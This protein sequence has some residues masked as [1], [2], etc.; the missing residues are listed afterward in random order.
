[1]AV[2]LWEV[3]EVIFNRGLYLPELDFWLDPREAKDSAFVSHAHADHF[4]R[5]GRTL[6]STVTAVLLRKRFRMPEERL[7]AAG[8][9]AT[10]EREGFRLRLLAAGH[11]SGSAM[12]HITRKR[13]G[14]TL[15]YTGDFKVRRSRTAEAV[16][17]MQA[18]TLITETTFGLP[19]FVFPPQLEVEAAVLR[20]VHDAFADGEVPVLLGYS[21]GKAQE[22]VALL[23]EN[24]IPVLSHPAVAEM[25]AACRL[26]GVDL[27]EPVVFEG[28]AQEG[29]AIVAPPN[30]ARSKLMREVK[31]RRFAML[32]GWALQE[33]SFFRYPSQHV[34]ALSDHADH[35]GLLECITRVRPK[36]VL[37]VHGY[38]K[39]FAAELRG[40]GMDAWSAMGGDQLELSL[41][42][43]S[44]H[45]VGAAS[46][47]HIRPICQLADFSD[48]C[49]L[50]GETSSR[51][52]KVDYLVNYLRGI[53]EEEDLKCVARWLCG[54]ALPRQAGRR[55]LEPGNVLLKR[56]LLAIPGMKPERYREVF[57]VEK[58]DMARTARVLLQE[59][60]LAPYPLK[61]LDLQEFFLNLAASSDS[62][63]RVALLSGR[64]VELHPS[65]GETVVK[66]LTGQL[67]IGLETELVEEALGKAFE[68]SAADV[69]RAC[70]LTGDLG[71][72]ACLA[73]QGRLGEAVL[74]LLVPV[75]GMLAGSFQKSTE[76][77]GNEEL[78]EFAG[79]PFPLPI[80]LEPKYDGIRAQLHKRGGEIGLFAHDL[81]PL[82]RVFPELIEA[83]R[84]LPGDFILDGELI[85]YVEGRKLGVADLQKRLHPRRIGGDLFMETKQ[86]AAAIP[87]SFI[88]FDVLW[89]EGGSLLDQPLEMRRRVL[90]ALPL[91]GMVGRSKV[92]MT[93]GAADVAGEFKQA[94]QEGHEGLIAKDPASHYFPGAGGE[95]WIKL[96][97]IMP[98]LNCLVIYAE[99]GA[100]NRPGSLGDYTIA[101]RDEETDSLRAIGKVSS[102]LSADEI[103]E[104]TE[105][106]KKHTLGRE[107]RKRR[108]VPNLLLEIAFQSIGKSARYDCGFFLRKARIKSI[109]YGKDSS[110]IDT[111]DTIKSLLPR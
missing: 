101:V 56:A 15:L 47:R 69:R 67:G 51:L 48:V 98:T 35:P 87:L 74:T 26:A 8:F 105:H 13:D 97:G 31:N 79:L 109:Q 40:K 65:E 90:D 41:G 102:G 75:S 24:G 106:F 23:A 88:A 103:E 33:T 6:C 111:L 1:M 85:A 14:A 63:E 42:R 27:P 49:R 5:H 2:S 18:D 39:E 50:V 110:N 82:D 32:T 43:T 61:V 96:E 57:A 77:A 71:E 22:A 76:V 25:T 91:R 107:R 58:K 34:I 94:I 30:A 45:S 83:A 89:A 38:A 80:W 95:S 36:R 11:I 92:K 104:L 84:A 70:M 29:H 73:K 16:N 12:L 9:G 28:M 99:Q 81:R 72:T 53:A 7:E 64:L 59:V 55:G 60:L 21:L 46:P 100:G 108:V 20:F 19:R 52:A 68:A 62:L 54:E 37:T 4:A 86:G 10:I 93:T 78:V 17:F 44:A 66:L 3:I